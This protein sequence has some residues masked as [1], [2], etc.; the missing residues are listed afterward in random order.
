MFLIKH[1]LIQQALEQHKNKLTSP[2]EILRCLGSFEIAALTGSYLCCAHIGM[3]VLIDGIASAIAALITARLCPE[4]EQWFLY[5]H[6]STDPAHKL[7]L[8]IL[9]AQPLL[10]LNQ[11]LDDIAGITSTLSLLHLAC[12]NHNEKIIFSKESLLK[13]YS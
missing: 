11:D 6:A 7:I 5:S 10:Q 3:P 1:K 12:A 4:A 8:K 9:G 13:R 2:L